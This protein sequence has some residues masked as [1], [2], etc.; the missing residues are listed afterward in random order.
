MAIDLEDSPAFSVDKWVEFA[1]HDLLWY[2]LHL[3][4]P[5][6]E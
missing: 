6:M 2:K 5:S 3:W 4:P 1:L